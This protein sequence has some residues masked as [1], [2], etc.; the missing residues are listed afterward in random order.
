MA[1]EKRVKFDSE[2]ISKELQARSITPTTASQFI[3]LKN[4]NYLTACMS[5]GLIGEESLKKLCGF[6]QVGVR[7]V[8][9]A[10][11]ELQKG[12]SKQFN[13]EDL[14]VGLNSM[15]NLQ[16]KILAEIKSQNEILRNL[17]GL[18]KSDDEILKNI[19]SNLNSNTEKVKA[20]FTEIKYNN[21]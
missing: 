2:R 3:M 7:E 13:Y 14:I 6:L 8:T 11:N 5:S 4:P 16:N 15:Y 9:I 10:E 20:I 1:N 21:K 12:T 18:K 19:N 17:Y